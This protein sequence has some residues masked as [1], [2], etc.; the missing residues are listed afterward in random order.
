MLMQNIMYPFTRDAHSIS[1]FTHFDSSI[2]H[3]HIMDFIND[4]WSNNLNRASRTFSVTCAHMITP[5]HLKP[6][7][8]YSNRR[9]HSTSS[10]Q[11]NAKYKEIDQSG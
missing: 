5:K 6:F 2:I 9:N 10:I 1:N 4:F 3:Y 11:T 8:N 7:I